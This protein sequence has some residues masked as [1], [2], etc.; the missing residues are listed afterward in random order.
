MVPGRTYRLSGAAHGD[1]TNKAQIYSIYAIPTSIIWESTPS[2]EWQPFDIQFFIAINAAV[3]FHA[4]GGIGAISAYDDM[5]ISEEEAMNAIVDGD[6]EDVGVDAWAATGCT[7]TKETTDP[8]EGLRN[9]RITNTAANGYAQKIVVLAIGE[10]YRIIGRARSNGV[11]TPRVYSPSATP[12]PLIWTGTMSTEW[13]EIDVTFTAGANLLRFYAL[14][15]IGEYV[16]FDALDMRD[17][18]GP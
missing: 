16:E 18:A 13:Q 10:T 2:T 4:I 15:A 11:T 14:G 3:R 5:Y 17:L 1:G 7:L 6:C 9:L 12:S 8:Y